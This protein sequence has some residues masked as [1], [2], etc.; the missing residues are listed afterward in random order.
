MYFRTDPSLSNWYGEHIANASGWVFTEWT[1]QYTADNT[2][3]PTCPSTNDGEQTALGFTS[4]YDYYGTNNYEVRCFSDTG[5][6]YFYYWPSADAGSI[7]DPIDLSTMDLDS[8]IYATQETHSSWPDQKIFS[9]V[10]ER[11]TFPTLARD[12]C[13]SDEVIISARNSPALVRVRKGIAVIKILMNGLSAVAAIVAA[14][15]WTDLVL[16]R[17]LAVVA[18]LAPFVVSSVLAVMP[19]ASMAKLSSTQAYDDTLIKSLDDADIDGVIKYFK[20]LMPFQ[21]GYI[22]DTMKS[23]YEDNR[24]TG[25]E[26]SDLALQ[27]EFRLKT[28]TAT[29]V[30]L[31]LTALSLPGA[32]TK[33]AVQVKEFFPSVAWL[34]WL[35]R[36]L[37]MFY[38]PWASAIFCSMSQIFAGPFVTCAVVCFLTTRVIDLTYNAHSHTNVYSSYQD[39]RTARRP[40]LVVFI[41]LKL[42]LIASVVF[43]IAALL[44]DKYLKR[45]GIKALLG[46]VTNLGAESAHLIISILIGFIAKS[47]N[48][49]IMFSDILLLMTVYVANAS[50]SAQDLRLAAALRRVF[51][52]GIDDVAPAGV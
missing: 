2:Y 28:M 25:R 39:Y 41:V 16:S 49:I 33:A 15:K 7:G 48:T 14:V 30:P 24:Y 23:F 22:V 40:S 18:W 35:I 11:D 1:T 43:L 8:I 46:E 52:G 9:A 26:V 19:L 51:Q 27:I 20:L 44:T 32:V 17:R 47:S 5:T 38:L 50:T 12:C 31:A 37:P 13:T 21:T 10:N 42:L 6:S 34:G 36:L 29:L 45:L 3:V 4:T